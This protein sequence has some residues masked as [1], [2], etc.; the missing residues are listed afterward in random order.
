MQSYLPKEPKDRT[1]T[2]PPSNLLEKIKAFGEK[3]RKSEEVVL[4]GVVLP[5]PIKRKLFV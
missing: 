2:I 1:L 3:K 5:K 4:N